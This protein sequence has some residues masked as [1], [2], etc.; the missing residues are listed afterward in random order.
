MYLLFYKYSKVGYALVQFQ[1]LIGGHINIL[2]CYCPSKKNSDD[3]LKKAD[4]K[5]LLILR[6]TFPLYYKT[7]SN[8]LTALCHV[9]III[10]I[11][12]DPRI[13]KGVLLASTPEKVLFSSPL[14]SFFWRKQIYLTYLTFCK[15]N[16]ALKGDRCSRQPKYKLNL[17]IILGI[18]Q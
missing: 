1:P 14:P 6:P 9:Y 13:N 8:I 10:P 18:G 16:H 3:R 11:N 2:Y 15:L 4:A 17:A 12:G 7:F 5:S